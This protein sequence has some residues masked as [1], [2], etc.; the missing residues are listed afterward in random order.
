MLDPTFGTGGIVTTPIGSVSSIKATTVQTD[1]KVV[2]AGL[3]HTASNQDFG[4]ARYNT[5][6][7]LD[8]TFNGT[9]EVITSI[10]AGNAPDIALSIAIQGDGKIVVAGYTFNGGNS[11]FSMVRYN[12]DG[13]LDNGFDGD[14]KLITSFGVSKNSEI[15]G[16]AIQPDG[17]IV[18]VGRAY[19]GTTYD[20]ALARYNTDGTPD[21]SFDNDGKVITPISVGDDEAHSIII[22][23]DGKIVLGI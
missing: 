20:F 13:S 16:I 6:G 21:N 10:G 7:T 3:S 23:S 19:S 17:K 5:N 11:D 15:F 4:V 18:A 8:N 22:Q 2:V 12:T 9:G 1:G 14:G